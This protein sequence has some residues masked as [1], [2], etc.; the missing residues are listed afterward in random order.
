[1]GA[2]L[3]VIFAEGVLTSGDDLQFPVFPALGE[4]IGQKLAYQDSASLRPVEPDVDCG[5]PDMLQQF[6]DKVPVGQQRSDPKVLLVV[7]PAR[8]E[9]AYSAFLPPVGQGVHAAHAEPAVITV[10]RH[11]VSLLQGLK[12]IELYII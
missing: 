12:Q 4:G 11:P 6:P 3:L 7:I 1:M 9:T 2:E 5:V 10:I 8:G